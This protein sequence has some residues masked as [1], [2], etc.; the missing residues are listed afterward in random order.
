MK[1]IKTNFHIASGGNHDTI[2]VERF[3]SSLNK[4]LHIFCSD[5][6][7]TRSFWEGYQMIAY[8]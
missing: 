4:D 6:D 2:L 8:E 5:R 7:T 1:K 3:N